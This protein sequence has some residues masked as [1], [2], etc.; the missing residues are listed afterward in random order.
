MEKIL[1]KT[2]AGTFLLEATSRGLSA[3]HFPGQ[4]Q[5][6]TRLPCRVSPFL[7]YAGKMLGRY[8]LDYRISL[9]RVKIDS[10]SLTP[11]QK[12]VYGALRRAGCRLI[13]YSELAGKSGFRNAGRAVG[14]AMRRN[15][16][17]I[18]VPCH[19]V[20]KANGDL[21]KYSCGAR[22][23]CYLLREEGLL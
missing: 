16:V 6:L 18:F 12:K 7:R 11:F 22:W 13:S 19:R 10:S 15:R 17:P 9:N 14:S 3:V 20:V 8:F 23:K 5:K 2:S 1:V 21:G 4:F